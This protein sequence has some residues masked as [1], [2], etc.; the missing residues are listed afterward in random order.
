MFRGVG[1]VD[2]AVEDEDEPLEDQRRHSRR[3]GS[4]RQ[5]QQLYG[6]EE[7]E[8]EDYLPTSR[9]SIRR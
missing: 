4:S 1:H 9:R 7:E 2:G 3:L 8:E 6:E 5:Q